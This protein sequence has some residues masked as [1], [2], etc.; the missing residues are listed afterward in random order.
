M[1]QI[2]ARFYDALVKDDEATKDWVELV[3]KTMHRFTAY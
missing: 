3:L 1:Y 2:L